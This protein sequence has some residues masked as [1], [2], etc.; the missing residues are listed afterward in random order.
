MSKPIPSTTGRYKPGVG[1]T[2]TRANIDLLQAERA[3]KKLEPL[4][5]AEEVCKVLLYSEC[6]GNVSNVV[7]PRHL[8]RAALLM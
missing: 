4:Y 6:Y 7:K 8:Y 3:E 1:F 2:I 5:T